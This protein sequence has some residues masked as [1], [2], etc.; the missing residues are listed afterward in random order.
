MEKLFVAVPEKNLLQRWDL[1]TLER[2]V[3][4][5]VAANV[6][7]LLM[8]RGSAG[9]LFVGIGEGD[10]HNRG[11]PRFAQAPSMFLNPAN[12]KE[13]RYKTER[14]HGM[15][16]DGA[17]VSADGTLVVGRNDWPGGVSALLRGSSIMM[18]HDENVFFGAPTGDGLA[19]LSSSGIYSPEL[20]RRGDPPGNKTP[21]PMAAGALIPA[22]HGNT[23]LQVSPPPGDPF[24][25]EGSKY[26]AAV[27]LTGDSRPL[28]QLGELEGLRV[29]Q[30]FG[31]GDASTL[32]LQKRVFFIPTAK[33]IIV[34]SP[35]HDKLYLHRFDLNEA[36]EKSE[37][38]Y[39]LV[40][41]SPPQQYAAGAKFSYQAE[42]KSRKGGVKYKIESGPKGMS[43]TPAGLLT[44]DVPA[45]FDE[46]ADVILA[47][48]DSSGQE[49]FHT[50]HLARGAA[51]VVGE[52]PKEPPP[53]VEGPKDP[54]RVEPPKDPPM[55]V[56]PAPVKSCLVRLPAH[57]LPIQ[58]APLR[59]AT[60]VLSLPGAVEDVCPGGNGRFLILHL[61]QQRKL[62]VFDANEAKIVKYLPV[63]E[64]KICFAAGMDKLMVVLPE[65]NIVQRWS[66]TTFER[67]VSAPLPSVGTV[68]A[69]LM[70][71]N[72]DGCL[73]LSSGG[74]GNHD[75][76]IA[77]L[78]MQTLKEIPL[79]N[80]PPLR[81]SSWGRGDP[82]HVHISANG[83]V[84][85]ARVSGGSPA[86]VETLILRGEKVIPHYEHDSWGDIIP[87]AE[88]R[89]IHTGRGRYTP[90]LK[91]IG[92]SQGSLPALHG[93]L[94]VS[95]AGGDG[96]HN[97]EATSVTVSVHMGDDTR[98]L[99]TLRDLAGLDFE[100]DRI[101]RFGEK[102][103][104]P[105]Q[106]RFFLIPQAK[107]IAILDRTGEKLHLHR[108][109]LDEVLE[110][111]GVDYLIVTSQPLTVAVKG[112]EYT[113][114]LV[115]KSKKGGLKYK[116]ESG[117]KGMQ[118]S[119]DGKLA[120]KVPADCPDAEVDVI[121][122]VG[123]TAGQEVFHTFKIAVQDK[124]A[125]DK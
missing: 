8:G 104:L 43:I 117:P 122:T 35:T 90:E 55:E 50:F 64:E 59:D 49:I 33:V 116:V 115:V 80:D 102:G 10:I 79:A 39:L 23:Y 91:K 22:T 124:A 113:Y 101:H 54:P 40:T 65:K 14:S 46:E 36:L 11:G 12:M 87:D 2:E 21:F 95:I 109:D 30:Q 44:W 118:I 123:D 24:P 76:R 75:G 94:W 73:V 62:A 96:V 112:Q 107:L 100:R 41:S 1:T 31:R 53:K 111:S 72:T 67:E 61:P 7:T 68:S 29:T 57:V 78:D 88:G 92:D 42:V 26:K 52:A 13:V 32:P 93:N 114:P 45:G 98:P 105:V 25:R 125:L 56:R 9:P 16:A 19:I 120:W 37:I 38:D 74:P 20:M 119:S 47:I 63:A 34:L 4:V 108:F 99:A 18:Y 15:F 106:K 27:F 69:A 71:W 82:I 5:P 121:L 70:G 66:L 3:T 83:Q 103:S 110:K 86:G 28:V 17:Q 77:F 81:A 84:I 58:P 60:Q 85:G 97:R 51:A 89:V 6:Q 48:S